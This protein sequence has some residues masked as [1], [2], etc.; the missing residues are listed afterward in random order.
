MMKKMRLLSFIALCLV[1]LS[2]LLLPLAAQ[3]QDDGAGPT[4]P[5][6]NFSPPEEETYPSPFPD[7]P[8]VDPNNA[9]YKL[10]L[11]PQNAES[12]ASD[13]RQTSVAHRTNEQLS[14]WLMSA[15]PAL[16]NYNNKDMNKQYA[17]NIKLFNASGLAL[18]RDYL[19][20]SGFLLEMRD[21]KK[22]LT[23]MVPSAPQLLNDGVAN[24]RYKWL[25]DVPLMVTLIPEGASN[26]RQQKPDSRQ[27]IVRLQLT[28]VTENEQRGDGQ[29]LDNTIQIESWDV[30]ANTGN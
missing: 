28:R 1:L 19:A 5:Q 27:L 20:K 25:Y 26:L 17:E 13:T 8:E 16:F 15:V 21:N 4:A 23:A 29:V 11:G 9:L 10:Y 12:V 2:A 7:T 3:A 22:Q 6:E 24:D 30:R 14:S 18:Y